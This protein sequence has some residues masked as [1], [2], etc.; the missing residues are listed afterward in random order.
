MCGREARK[1]TNFWVVKGK[2]IVM[3]RALKRKKR[4]LFLFTFEALKWNNYVYNYCV[5]RCDIYGPIPSI[6]NQ[7]III[8]IKYLSIACYWKSIPINNHTNLSHR[9]VIDNPYES[10]IN[11]YQV[12]LIDID[13]H[14]L[15]ILLIGYPGIV[16]HMTSFVQKI[17]I[18][19]SHQ[20]F[21]M[22]QT[23]NKDIVGIVTFENKES[24]RRS[25]RNFLLYLAQ[26]KG[27]NC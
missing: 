24:L 9:W 4:V 6:C 18:D 1:G 11:W 20:E 16:R 5:Q 19:S 17:L 26:M 12:A 3:D 14:R 8:D 15:S 13:W 25:L 21:A 2:W 27:N 10:I 7:S 22:K 23:R